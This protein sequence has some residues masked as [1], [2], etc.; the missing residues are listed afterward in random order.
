MAE[1][2]GGSGLVPSGDPDFPLAECPQCRVIWNAA[3]ERAAQFMLSRKV[4]ASEF[5]AAELRKM[6]LPPTQRTNSE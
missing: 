2:C 3:I 1:N 4:S 5:Y 6:K